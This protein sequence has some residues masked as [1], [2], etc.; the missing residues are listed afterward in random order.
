MR[1]LAHQLVDRQYDLAELRPCDAPVAIQIVQLERP[2]QLLVDGP[3]EQSGQ[4]HQHVLHQIK[5]KPLH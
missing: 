2:P 3:A 4:S 5:F 1:S